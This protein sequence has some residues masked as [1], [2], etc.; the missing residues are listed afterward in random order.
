MTT[1]VEDNQ[2]NENVLKIDDP[3]VASLAASDTFTLVDDGV[4]NVTVSAG[5]LTIDTGKTYLVNPDFAGNTLRGGGTWGDIDSNSTMA[6]GTYAGRTA[7][8]SAD[9]TQ[10]YRG[11][12]NLLGSSFVLELDYY[13]ITA[14]AS[15]ATAGKI[16]C[17]GSGSGTTT[18]G[19]LM[20]LCERNGKVILRVN[21]SVA[22]EKGVTTGAWNHIKVFTI[23]GQIHL[24]GAS[25]VNS[26]PAVPSTMATGYV[27][28]DINDFD[29]TGESYYDTTGRYY[30]AIQLYI[31]YDRY[32][33]TP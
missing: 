15:S 23:D 14:R 8:Y 16:I 24:E 6:F 5:T 25:V 32:T 1:E 27:R 13:P 31:E 3:V 18:S 11:F 19:N 30:S 29:M 7:M 4:G 21:G 26:T 9:H 10:D 28:L 22:A 17:I 12:Q 2:I 33:Y 20:Y